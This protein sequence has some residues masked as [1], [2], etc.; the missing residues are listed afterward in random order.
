[1]LVLIPFLFVGYVTAMQCLTVSA[2]KL[3]LPLV[4]TILDSQER[5]NTYY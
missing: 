4:S 5:F 3:Y 2:P 1:M